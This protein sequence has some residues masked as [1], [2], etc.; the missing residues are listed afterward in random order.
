MR[1]QP[2]KTENRNRI[3]WGVFDQRDGEL[4]SAFI[5]K[6]RKSCEAACLEAETYWAEIDAQVAL[7]DTLRADKAAHKA[8]LKSAMQRSKAL[9]ALQLAFTF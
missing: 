7:L 8:K 4:N 1:F 5:W 9:A 2:R 6:T 3:G